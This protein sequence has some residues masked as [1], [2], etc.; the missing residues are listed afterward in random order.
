VPSVNIG[1]FHS[2]ISGKF[3]TIIPFVFHYVVTLSTPLVIYG[4]FSHKKLLLS[5]AVMWFFAYSIFFLQV[6]GYQYPDGLLAFFFLCAF[7]CINHGAEDKKYITLAALFLGCCAWSKNEGIILALIFM[8]FYFR[9]FFSR[10]SIKSSLV[11][12]AIPV[13][14]LVI[15][16]RTCGETNDMVSRTN[17]QTL[18][19]LFQGDRYL[20][21][22]NSFVKNANMK[23]VL[24]EWACI[25]YVLISIFVKKRPDKQMFT[26]LTCLI[27]YFMVYVLT[28][29][30]LEWHLHTSQDRLMVH[31]MPAFVYVITNRI[32][33]LNMK[34]PKLIKSNATG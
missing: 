5:L 29:N 30:P 20:T 25:A 19:Y 28:P 18:L 16:H 13:V 6:S 34:I 23:F 15:L 27:A 4:E 22:L 8:L 33:G 14:L 2:L 26:L 32:S 3:I 7:I 11:A 12:F 21:V 10:E 1:I 17:S 9:D 24:V 31:L